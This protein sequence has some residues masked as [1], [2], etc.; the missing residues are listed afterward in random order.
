MIYQCSRCKKVFDRR[1]NY[2]RHTNRKRKCKLVENITNDGGANSL[3]VSTV[4]P[5]AMSE[6]KSLIESIKPLIPANN[7]YQLVPSNNQIVLS[8]KEPEYDT[9]SIYYTCPFCDGKYTRKD[10][11][12]RHMKSYCQNKIVMIEELG[13]EDVKIIM[14]RHVKIENENIN[15]KKNLITKKP[16]TVINN[17]ITNNITNNIVNNINIQINPF[18]QENVS[19]LTDRD[20]FR[21]INRCAQALPLLVKTIH[22]D[23][24]E[25][26]NVYIPNKKEPY[27][28]VYNDNQWMLKDV[29][30]VLEDMIINN[31]QR[32]E[33]FL[34]ENKS[35]FDPNKYEKIMTMVNESQDGGLNSVHKKEIKMILINYKELI[36]THVDKL[37][38]QNLITLD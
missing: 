6:E 25:N 5:E 11:R 28:M 2:T 15:I 32:L 19:T 20:L 21:I 17:N 38:S 37:L 14:D 4:C 27:A 24:E 13:K 3:N 8:S 30:I 18:G 22:V 12:N 31:I 16:E 1:G 33:E 9:N 23:M 29:E 35:K 36:K 34:D 7:S 10:N 26:R